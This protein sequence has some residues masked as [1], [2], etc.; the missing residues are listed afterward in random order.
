MGKKQIL[1]LVSL[2]IILFAVTSLY[3]QES[4]ILIGED[5]LWKDVQIT[6]LS[7]SEGKRGFLDLTNSD[8]EYSPDISSDMILNLNQAELYDKTGNYTFLNQV[9]YI[10]KEGSIG[11]G[12]AFFDGSDPLIIESG[13]DSL[14]S[15]SSL[16]GDFT[17]EFRI[18]PATLK[19]GSTVFL[20]KGLQM[21]GKYLMPQEVRCTISNRQLVWDF[22]NF[23][24]NPDNSIKRISLSG[25]KL[26]PDIWSH[27][28]ITFNSE[29]GLLEY[30]INNIPSANIY[31][32]KSGRESLEFNIP[33]IGNQQSFPIE[34][35][36]NFSGLLDE[37][38]ISKKVVQDPTLHSYTTTGYL[39]TGIIDLKVPNSLLLEISSERS[40]PGNTTII[41]QYSIS[42][43]KFE[44]L[45]PDL[46]WMDF[47][48]ST[49]LL[50]SGQF[51]KIRSQLFSETATELAP[52]LSNFIV[53]YKKAHAPTPP[54]NV[55]AERLDETIKISWDNSI[56]P[57]IKGYMV[58]Y[59][60][61]P[62]KYFSTGS[63]ID[64]G[65]NNSIVLNGLSSNRRYYISV[66]SYKSLDPIL[67]SVFSREI[68][69]IP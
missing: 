4:V 23:F 21:K 13:I 51:V 9:S 20:W 57:E 2:I 7:I 49:P 27:H 6:N 53:K 50:K 11:G 43:D 24:L 69:I 29:T 30:K 60:E 15:P 62:K 28:M 66:T 19:E 8:N 67:E 37:F 47:I 10:Q 5:D 65:L 55:Q 42:S 58:Y 34:L 40:E 41:Y 14:F 45:K 59:G 36:E 12:A 33:I 35:G 52:V 48:P 26:I 64:S 25:D 32:S 63:P 39:E 22:E 68:S 56:D 44:L 54:L 18:L 17:I 46:L 38:R 61:E 31:T 16:W 1:H 3:S